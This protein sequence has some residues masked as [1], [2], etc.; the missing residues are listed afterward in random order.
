MDEHPVQANCIEQPGP[1]PRP[2]LDRELL[3]GMVGGAVATRVEGEQTEARVAEA[4]VH[5]TE[6]VASEQAAAELDH[7]RPVVR[8]AQLVV[9]PQSVIQLRV[10]HARLQA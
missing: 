6:V 8:S 7:D 4:V 10:R 9:D 5:G 2:A 1:V 3:V